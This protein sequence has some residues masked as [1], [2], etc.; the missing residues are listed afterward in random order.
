[1][2]REWEEGREREMYNYN[3]G[4]KKIKRTRPQLEDGVVVCVSLYDPASPGG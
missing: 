3:R 4:N 1:M 2:R